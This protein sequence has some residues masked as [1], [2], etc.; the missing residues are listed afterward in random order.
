MQFIYIEK[1][2]CFR[3]LCLVNKICT[4]D[5]LC[6]RGWI[7][8]N[9][10]HLCRASSES[11]NHLFVEC[12]FGKSLRAYIAEALG[13]NFLWQNSCLE[14]NY[15]EWITN[16]DSLVFLPFFCNWTIWL[17]RNDC[18]F[19]DFVPSIQKTTVRYLNFTKACPVKVVFWKE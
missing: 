6:H 13:I 12:I 15:I 10:C 2:K 9:T 11:K 4:W 16:D 18:I 3:W 1:I 17:S 7:G 8:P 5:N 14:D 19:N